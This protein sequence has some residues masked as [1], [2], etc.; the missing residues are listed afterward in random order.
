MVVLTMDWLVTRDVKCAELVPLHA[1]HITSLLGVSLL[2]LY[3]SIP[4]RMLVLS[5]ADG[6][7]HNPHNTDHYR[8]RSWSS[9]CSFGQT[10]FQMLMI[11]ILLLAMLHTA[12]Q[13]LTDIKTYI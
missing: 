9:W 8:P 7:V 13:K 3:C 5:V 1:T 12:V 11:L 10:T 4:R 6:T 2:N